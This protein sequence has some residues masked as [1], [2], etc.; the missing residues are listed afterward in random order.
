MTTHSETAIRDILA[1]AHAPVGIQE[2]L[3]RVLFPFA[4]FGIVLLTLLL[5][6]WKLLIPAFTRVELK[7]SPQDPAALETT[8]RDMREKLTRIEGKRLALIL[9]LDDSPYGGLVREKIDQPSF[10]AL[11][12]QLKTV[13]RTFLPEQSQAVILSSLI[14]KGDRVV[15]LTG[16]VRNVGLQSM[17]V[18]AQFVEAVKGMPGIERVDFPSFKREQDPVAGFHS[19]F[20]FSIH[21]K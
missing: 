6:S 20:T 8:V 7:G 14:W 21:L 18:L 5:L 3:R 19:P 2:M 10:I 4:L 13:A 9:P 1:G 12:T 17:A 16:D 15:T 11:F